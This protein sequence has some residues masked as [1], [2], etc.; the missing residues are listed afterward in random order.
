MKLLAIALSSSVLVACGGGGGGTSTAPLPTA[1][2]AVLNSSNQNVAAEDAASTAFMPMLGAQTLTGAQTTDETALFSIA[3][4]QMAKLPAYMADAKAES[5][6]TGVVQSQTAACPLGGS[7]TVSVND[8]DNNGVLSAGDSLTIV[9]NSCVVSAG[10]TTGSLG[11]VI[12][13]VAGNYQSPTSTNYTLGVTMN[14]GN[15]TVTT[16]GLVA[17]VNGS[18]SLTAAANG[19]NTLDE[20]IST[21]SLTMAGTYGGVTRSRSLTNY[22]ATA[23]RVP[24]ASSYQTSYSID[25]TLTSTG[26]S[27]QAISV[28]TTTAFVRQ[29]TDVYPSSGVMLLTDSSNAK[30]KLTAL[31]NTQVKEELDANGDGLYE[32]NTTVNWTSLM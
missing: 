18:L 16:P 10:T 13:A 19:V 31:S 32:S 21:P 22:S 4:E 28:A 3:R 6:L 2:T 29:S 12:N 20:T 15:F 11:F 25:A 8:A 23:S 17:S 9:S 5:A 7:L 27:S 1:P 14:F 24:T 26:L 30:L